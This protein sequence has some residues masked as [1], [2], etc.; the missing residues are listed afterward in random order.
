MVAAFFSHYGINSSATKHNYTPAWLPVAQ[1]P[2]LKEGGGGGVKKKK[3][4]YCRPYIK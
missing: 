3:V 1:L 2:I 4:P